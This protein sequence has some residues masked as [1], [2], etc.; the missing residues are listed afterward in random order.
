MK[1]VIWFLA[2]FL[3]AC[4][5]SAPTE[6]D[7]QTAVAQTVEASIPEA[8]LPT[9]TP[10]RQ[11]GIV[12]ASESGQ[13]ATAVPDE[14]AFPWKLIPIAYSKSDKALQYVAEPGWAYLQVFFALENN[15]DTFLSFQDGPS[16]IQVATK[17][18]YIYPQLGN[19]TWQFDDEKEI[20]D[21]ALTYSTFAQIWT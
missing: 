11:T 13:A 10:S 2:I 1:R 14:S 3:V 15:S 5:P 16:G 20:F 9:P 12:P 6:H 18:G 4:N 8:A 7:F 19:E 17:E 21:S